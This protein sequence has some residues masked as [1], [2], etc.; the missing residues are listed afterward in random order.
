VAHPHRRCPLPMSRNL[1]VARPINASFSAKRKWPT[2]VSPHSTSSTGNTP[3]AACSSPAVAAAVVDA[4]AAVVVA[5]AA[6]AAAGAAAE[7]A[8]LAAEVAVAAGSGSA[9]AGTAGTAAMVSTVRTFPTAG[10][11]A[12]L[13]EHAACAKSQEKRRCD[14]RIISRRLNF[15]GE[16]SVRP[17][18]LRAPS[19]N[20]RWRAG[21]CRPA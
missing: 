8:G 3:A 17:M 19:A 9:A 21:S 15:P 1:T 7:A 4:E 10:G 13:G 14:G 18:R 12:D 2:S 16:P 5:A 20:R 11:A 6:G